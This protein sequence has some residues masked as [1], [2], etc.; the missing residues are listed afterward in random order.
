MEDELRNEVPLDLY[1]GPTSIVDEGAGDPAA[2]SQQLPLGK[3]AWENFERLCLRLIL[4][5]SAVRQ[6]ALYGTRGQ[7]QGGI[8]FYSYDDTNK[9][10][11]YQCKRVEEMT[12]SVIRAAVD[13]FLEGPWSSRS[14]QFILCSSFD[15]TDNKLQE[16]IVAS[17]E[18]LSKVEVGFGTMG[19]QDILLD[20]KSRPELVFDFFGKRLAIEYCGE[21]AVATLK[22][23]L[24]TQEIQQLRARLR[25]V[26]SSVFRFDARDAASGL[27]VG[28]R[29]F[30]DLDVLEQARVDIGHLKVASQSADELAMGSDARLF[31]DR[32][33]MGSQPSP[34]PPQAIP[35]NR[36]QSVMRWIGATDHPHLIV[37]GPGSGKSTVLRTVAL[38]L[39]AEQPAIAPLVERFGERI[40]I[41]IPFASWAKTVAGKDT[42]DLGAVGLTKQWLTSLGSEDLHDLVAQAFEDERLL[43]LVDGLD[44]YGDEAGANT[45]LRSLV[46]HVEN[47]NCSLVSSGRPQAIAA[48]TLGPLGWK[49][50]VL[51]PLLPAQQVDLVRRKF[52][53]LDFGNDAASAMVAELDRRPELDDLAETPLFL[54]YLVD[55]W[56]ADGTM[57]QT[58][59]DVQ[60]AVLRHLLGTYTTIRENTS[61]RPP[62]LTLTELS[63]EERFIAIADVALEMQL[64]RRSSLSASE[65]EAALGRSLETQ[66]GDT[67]A[68][69]DRRTMTRNLFRVLFEQNGILAQYAEDEFGVFHRAAH[70]YLSATALFRLDRETRVEL[71]GEHLAEESWQQSVRSLLCM[72]DV[73]DARALA[74]AVELAADTHP[75]IGGL[76][77]VLAEAASGGTLLDPQ[78]VRRLIGRAVTII[79]EQYWTTTR[80]DL[81]RSVVRGLRDSRSSDTALASIRRW[82][83]S[84]SYWRQH[85]FRVVGRWTPDQAVGDGLLRGLLGLDTEGRLAVALAMLPSADAGFVSSE[86]LLDR[87]TR[88]ADPSR[89]VTSLLAL[90]RSFPELAAPLLDEAWRSDSLALRLIAAEHRVRSGEKDESVRDVLIDVLREEALIEEGWAGFASSALL[91][92]WQNDLALRD[93]LMAMPPARGEFANPGD[94]K[95]EVI[96]T[97]L[98]SVFPGD[99]VVAAFLAQQLAGDH[100]FIGLSLTGYPWALFVE[101][102]RDDPSLVAAA[103]AWL[104]TANSA[105]IMEVSDAALIGRTPTAKR[106]LLA[107]ADE[108]TPHWAM[109][110]LLEG[111]GATDPE[112]R[113]KFLE[114]L[115]GSAKKASTIAFLIPDF[116]PDPLVARRRLLAIIE[117][118]MCDR[119]DFALE[120]LLQLGV[121]AGDVEVADAVFALRGTDR[122]MRQAEGRVVRLLPWDART[123]EL[124][125][126]MLHDPEGDW[127]NVA[128]ALPKDPDV[129][130]LVLD[131]LTPLEPRGRAVLLD[132]LLRPGVPD[133]VTSEICG[134]YLS[135]G[136][137]NLATTAAIG[138]FQLEANRDGIESV[139]PILTDEVGVAGP[140]HDRHSQAAFAA[141][142]SLDIPDVILNARYDWNPGRSVSVQVTNYLTPNFALVRE[143]LRKW[144]P[145]HDLFGDD[146]VSRLSD[147]RGTSADLWPELLSVADEYPDV[148]DAGMEYLA[149]AGPEG[150]ADHISPDVLTFL[151]RVEPGGMLL[152]RY[153]LA[154][155]GRNGADLGSWDAELYAAELLAAYFG[156][157]G[158]VLEELRA[159]IE[160]LAPYPEW[161]HFTAARV[162]ALG[163]GWPGCDLVDKAWS[164]QQEDDYFESESARAFLYGARASTEEFMSW[165]NGCVKDTRRRYAPTLRAR[166]RAIFSRLRRDAEVRGG[167]IDVALDPDASPSAR[168]S[169]LDM[170][171]GSGAELEPRLHAHVQERL[172]HLSRAA[173]E[174]PFSDIGYS[175]GSGEIVSELYLVSTFRGGQEQER[176][177]AATQ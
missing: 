153:C 83:P 64:A 110:S 86:A 63:H 59:S 142:L 77:S 49:T 41:W 33:A 4:A 104:P 135:D 44:E 34:L 94:L 21:D 176:V 139:R 116:E 97:L 107:F 1:L 91:E 123:K 101:N 113:A 65:L 3:V 98:V 27:E 155:V 74:G 148:R 22:R 72:G 93:L 119:L 131:R 112:V 46:V 2:L 58:R 11:T 163:D 175:L 8:D 39:L 137:M 75:H 19:Q 88:D 82:F 108:W 84:R 146:F 156:G 14:E 47:H 166:R 48:L 92:G 132:E 130:Q 170:L 164:L 60:S 6:C 10:S 165:L 115:D 16:E 50:A 150:W 100:P 7:Y 136:D 145:L 29:R 117:D 68:P 96:T 162:C 144:S 15:L 173:A 129:R 87:A 51:S 114:F 141:A 76:E 118:P 151:A 158:D 160:P 121:D 85:G 157:R 125:I 159:T 103:D 140:E 168:I 26:Y 17:R 133:S 81:I 105:A 61:E 9:Y 32:E 152:R 73:S 30:V 149:E 45:A 55:L 134:R 43:L 126:A 128:Y 171:L 167:A 111:W 80:V 169:M 154:L 89:R 106:V 66:L 57:P 143:V 18:R 67:V 127:A 161:W 31:I 56:I 109:R 62:E 52:A 102:F 24:D 36:R 174:P 122:W 25:G 69:G 147:G 42:A 124:A 95:H 99:A 172:E 177:E 70:E 78:D 90:E 53:V 120:G 23:R 28:Q 20:L 13:K 38:D 12:P 71:V 79:E 40:P 37:G 35:E 138:Y 5:R 54:S